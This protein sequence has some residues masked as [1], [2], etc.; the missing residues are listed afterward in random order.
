MATATLPLR[1]GPYATPI[2]ATSLQFDETTVIGL[3][4][5][6]TD[7]MYV[8]PGQDGSPRKASLDVVES[9]VLPRRDGRDRLQGPLIGAI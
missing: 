4:M 2:F 5:A 6:R 3:M 8:G 9:Q 1:C 7:S